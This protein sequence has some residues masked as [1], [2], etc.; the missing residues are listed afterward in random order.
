MKNPNP[1]R[2]DPTETEK[3]RA[4]CIYFAKKKLTVYPEH[5]NRFEVAPFHVEWSRMV[6]RH[7]RIHVQAPRDHGKSAFWSFAYPIWRVWKERCEGF[8]ISA[9]KDQTEKISNR[10]AKEIETNPEL[11]SLRPRKGRSKEG[12]STYTREFANGSV[13]HF[14]SMGSKVR[15]GHP[16]F[17]ICDDILHDTDMT[18]PTQRRRNITLFRGSISN[19]IHP[20]NQLIVVG[21]PFHAADLHAYLAKNSEYESRAYPALREVMVN[22]ELQLIPL[23]P[24]RY[25]VKHL[26]GRKREIGSVEFTREFLLNPISDDMS[27]FPMEFFE[28]EPVEQHA[29]SLGLPGEWWRNQ[30]IVEIY[31]GVDFAISASTKADYFVIFVVGLDAYGNRWIIDIERHHGLAY[32]RQKSR[33]IRAGRKYQ[34]GAIFMEAN[35]MQQIYSNELIEDTDLPITPYT[36]GVEKHSL[37]KG[38]PGIRTLLENRKYRIPRATQEDIEKTDVWIDELHNMA[39]VDGK[40]ESTGEH[41]DTV[42]AGWLCERAI[43][44]GSQ[45]GFSFAEEPGDRE[46]YEEDMELDREE[47]EAEERENEAYS[48]NL[49]EDD[50]DMYGSNL[51]APSGAD[52]L[53]GGYGW[54]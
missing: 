25:S 24:E 54:D 4:S 41:D 40:I 17:G 52:L 7:K 47:A 3:L 22:G 12:W 2:V 27:L 39:I 31:M 32:K 20:E 53:R 1:L 18:S 6:T 10:I 26:L 48:P 50:E 29:V 46:A 35:Q 42:M 21:T 45:F 16:T 14:S 44:K 5:T 38:V 15:G 23:W 43:E 49:F 19:M 28:K 11:V 9:S 34:P 51:G 8:I 37:R 30:G 36:T 33:I 13:I